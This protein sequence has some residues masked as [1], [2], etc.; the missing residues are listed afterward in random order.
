[1]S[2]SMS[3]SPNRGAAVCRFRVV[4]SH[5][6]VS[7]LGTRQI[8]SLCFALYSTPLE[9]GGASDN[10]NAIRCTFK[11]EVRN[12]GWR[13]QAEASRDFGLEASE[14]LFVDNFSFS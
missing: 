8:D 12:C 9:R 5:Y 10:G 11:F 7:S 13:V 14:S 6:A 3:P 1:M 2:P 4:A